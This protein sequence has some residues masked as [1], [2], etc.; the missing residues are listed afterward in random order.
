MLFV[1]LRLLRVTLRLRHRTSR[2]L[3]VAVYNLT[4]FDVTLVY[5]AMKCVPLPYVTSFHWAFF[6][7][8]SLD[9]SVRGVTSPCTVLRYVTLGVTSLRDVTRSDVTLRCMTR[10][11]LAPHD[12]ESTWRYAVWRS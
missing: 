6:D 10:H 9:I 4:S 7:V 8:T 11:D 12:T 5:M 1:V 3:G 2:F